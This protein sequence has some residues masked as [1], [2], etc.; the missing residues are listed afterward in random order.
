MASPW[1][2]GRT[3][4]DNKPTQ[5][6]LGA[7]RAKVLVVSDAVVGRRDAIIKNQTDTRT[8]ARTSYARACARFRV[9]LLEFQEHDSLKE[10]GRS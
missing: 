4:R 7:T 2:Q 1:C 6:A 5:Y 8:R 9:K 3:D 10:N